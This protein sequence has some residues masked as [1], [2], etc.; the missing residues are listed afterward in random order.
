MNQMA[1][2]SHSNSSE[3]TTTAALFVESAS[4]TPPRQQEFS[5]TKKVVKKSADDCQI[6]H[7]LKPSELLKHLLYDKKGVNA[8]T[9]AICNESG[10]PKN[11]GKDGDESSSAELYFKSKKHTESPFKELFAGLK[12]VRNCSFAQQITSNE[13][14]SDKHG[15]MDEFPEMVQSESCDGGTEEAATGHSTLNYREQNFERHVSVESGRSSISSQ[16][17]P[18]SSEDEFPQFDILSSTTLD[19]I[20]SEAENKLYIESPPH[21]DSSELCDI[22]NSECGTASLPPV[23][24]TP[25]TSKAQQRSSE[26]DGTDKEIEDSMV[27]VPSGNYCKNTRK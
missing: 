5:A 8:S 22:S 16:N 24:A 3:S 21:S 26:N 15:S 7:S 25:S 20:L 2:I 1:M 14:L 27:L 6:F 18:L 10:G 11:S 9:T 13:D 23:N 19:F 12:L 17:E 4:T